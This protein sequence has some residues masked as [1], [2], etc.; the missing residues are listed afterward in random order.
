VRDELTLAAAVEAARA[1]G[2]VT[3][4]P[5]LSELTTKLFKVTYGSEPPPAIEAFLELGLTEVGDFR[6]LANDPA[7][8]DG[9]MEVY[10][11]ELAAHRVFPLMSDGCG[12][13]HGVFI[14]G[15]GDPRVY[16]FEAIEGFS[17][18][19]WVSA[20]SLPRLVLSAAKASHDD[21]YWGTQ[22]A[23]LA[24]DPFLTAGR[25]AVFPWMAD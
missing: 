18:P 22:S 12:N 4:S 25:G 16:F 2:P 9:W 24:T 15:A 13:L 21:S 17:R 8:R 3:A 11:S 10:G 1:M 5:G 23:V 14:D 19:E 7:S 20:S 6:F